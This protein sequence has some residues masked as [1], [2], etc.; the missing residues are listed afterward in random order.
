[1]VAQFLRRAAVVLLLGLTAPLLGARPASAAVGKIVTITPP[2]VLQGHRYTVQYVSTDAYSSAD[3]ILFFQAS[4]SF[5]REKGITALNVL[6]DDA[7]P[8]T[9]D[10]ELRR[11]FTLYRVAYYL[12]ARQSKLPLGSVSDDF[13][14]DLHRVTQNPL[15]PEQF[16]KGL[17]DDPSEQS[18]ESFRSILSPQ[19]PSPDADEII[20]SAVQGARDGKDIVDAIN[21]AVTAAGK[22]NNPAI[23][24][25]QQDAA[26]VFK[27]WQKVSESGVE[28]M[29][30]G[31]R[32]TI[33]LATGL[34]LLSLMS[35]V[36]F[37]AR[38]DSERGQWLASY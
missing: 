21:L 7:V 36:L 20:Q 1:M 11:V 15:L 4:P 28:K 2:L 22:L 5:F 35:K 31:P 29:K 18:L 19:S 26:R 32:T 27:D 37:A 25:F 9:D 34:D 23:H 3:A 24:Q 30:I 14:N 6:R 13:S 12:Y 10:A 8:V 16:V 17:F 33:P 38:L